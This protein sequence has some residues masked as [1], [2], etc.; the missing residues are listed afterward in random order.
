MMLLRFRPTAARLV[1][2]AAAPRVALAPQQRW[3]GAN[4]NNRANADDMSDVFA[5]RKDERA[6]VTMDMRQLVKDAEE[7]VTKELVMGKD[8]PK[9]YTR[10]VVTHI[11]DMDGVD[12][13]EEEPKDLSRNEA[14]KLADRD[15]HDLCF[16]EAGPEGEA[17]CRLRYS[18]MYI[19]REVH[20]ATVAAKE[21]LMTRMRDVGAKFPSHHHLIKIRSNIERS[22]LRSKVAEGIR[23]LEEGKMARFEFRLFVGEDHVEGF[24]Q[25]TL[26]LLK[27]AA[28]RAEI[29]YRVAESTVSKKGGLVIVRKD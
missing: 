28:A 5:K 3:K 11:G 6:S 7:R 15:G 13:E 2:P 12:V 20:E 1:G 23:A 4:K 19:R 17:I 8:I 25:S 14:M 21:G 16:I 22:E 18:K 26:A 29:A 24:V 9:R 27:D 10:C